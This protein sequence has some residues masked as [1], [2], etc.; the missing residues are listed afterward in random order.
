VEH[1]VFFTGA[2]GAAQFRR[3][4]SLEEA[5]RVVE[6]LRNVEGVDDSRVYALAEVPLAFKTVYR[7][8]IAGQPVDAP[9][10][11]PPMPP[12][13]EMP[14]LVAEA[15]E[16]PAE[17]PVEAP[18]EAPEEPVAEAEEPVMAAVPSEPFAAEP[19]A[20]PVS[21]GRRGTGFFAR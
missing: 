4:P 3:T 18:A 7:V 8:E 21:N 14:E 6:H 19:V 20:E 13:P 16:A 9:A 12:M 17:A 11:L 1:V 15:A 10:P 5:V 2:D